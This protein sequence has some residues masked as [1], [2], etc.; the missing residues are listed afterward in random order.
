MSVGKVLIFLLLVI[1]MVSV[2]YSVATGPGKIPQI[3]KEAVTTTAAVPQ[4]DTTGAVNIPARTG[5]DIIRTFF[6]LITEKKIPQAIDMMDEETNPDERT[7]QQW[8][9]FFNSFENLDVESVEEYN[10][11]AW[12]DT[13]QTYRVLI[14]ALNKPGMQTLWENGDTTRWITLK[15]SGT[16][17][18]ILGIATGP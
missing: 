9:V 11:E 12:S 18:K 4:S 6:G 15:K 10:K 1:G 8:G 14:N 16:Q 5:E 17:W 7:R 2:A 13:S 3:T